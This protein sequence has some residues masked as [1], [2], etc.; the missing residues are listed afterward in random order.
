MQSLG[1]LKRGD[2]LEFTAALTDTATSAALTGAAAS[3][4]CHGKYSF[5]D[6]VLVEMAVSETATAGT[7]LFSASA[8]STAAFIPNRT[9]IFDI[10]YTNADGKV[11]STDDFSLFIAEDVTTDE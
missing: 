3:L 9:V 6:S 8:A 4:K 5:G 7:Y 2:T 10:Q 11:S 1:T